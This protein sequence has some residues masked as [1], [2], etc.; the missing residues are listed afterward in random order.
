MT[1]HAN[2]HSTQIGA[3]ARIAASFG[4]GHS[5][6]ELNSLQLRRRGMNVQDAVMYGSVGDY[7]AVAL[8]FRCM[9]A[10]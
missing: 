7:A 6:R 1:H 10:T 2:N 4:A 8:H 5:T 9:D 3:E